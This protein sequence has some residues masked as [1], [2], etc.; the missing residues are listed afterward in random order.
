MRLVASILIRDYN[1]KSVDIIHNIPDASQAPAG[2]IDHGSAS[3]TS[4]KTIAS[5]SLPSLGKP[6][7]L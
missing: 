2:K 4:A 3:G 6:I 5:E 7:F 1:T